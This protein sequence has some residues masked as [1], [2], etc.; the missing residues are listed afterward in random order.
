MKKS[1]FALSLNLIQTNSFAADTF[2]FPAA[3]GIATDTGNVH[4]TIS[5]S[6]IQNTIQC[7]LY[8]SI[9]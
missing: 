8:G 1:H 3:A 6:T 9:F 7:L 2:P 4:F 5:V